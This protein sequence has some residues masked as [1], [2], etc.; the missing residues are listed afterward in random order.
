MQ[1]Q[2]ALDNTMPQGSV[3]L[4]T[5]ANGFIASH[6]VEALLAAGYKVRGTTRTTSKLATLQARWHK[7]FGLDSF[8]TVAVEDITK[9]GAFDMALQGVS[10]VAHIASPTTFSTNPAEVIEP[11]V[12]GTLSILRSAAKVSSIK[13]FVLTS[14]STAA[15]W[16]KQ[17]VEF[18]VGEDTWNEESPALASSLPEDHPLK[19]WHIYSASKTLGE[20]AAWNFMKE[21]KP[22]FTLNT[23]LPDTNFGPI[24]DPQQPAS[25]AGLLRQ[26]F[27]GDI[28]PLLFV[29]PQWFVDV[30][31]TADIHLAALTSPT[32]AAGGARIWAA[33][34]PFN[35]ND[36][37][38]ALRNLY[39]KKTFPDDVEGIERDL[40]RIDN[41]RG[42]ELL[43]GWRSLEDAVR[44]NT[45]DLV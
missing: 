38:K 39:P 23:V 30:R 41:K 9:E 13:R 27:N 10:G 15:L 31:D 34:G 5:G 44:A 43:G 19:P 16:P 26:A 14:S 6:V 37:L 29:P 28:K 42:G 17:N 33:A 25:T 20:R 1:P 21:Q 11:S 7:K 36:V 35:I 12:N 22:T 4:V 18:D 40:S 45:E 3:V 8:E 32:L 2:T 24:L